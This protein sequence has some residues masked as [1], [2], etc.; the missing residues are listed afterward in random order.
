MCLYLV[1]EK[2]SPQGN[3]VVFLLFLTGICL[4]LIQLNSIHRI[5]SANSES[6]IS[7]PICIPIISFSSL[8]AVA[9]A[10][11]TMLNNIGESGHTCSWF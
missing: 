4:N 5:P 3:V 6:F 11:K 1:R 9:R 10:P 7:F 2:F 8:I